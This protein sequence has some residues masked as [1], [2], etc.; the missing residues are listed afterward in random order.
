MLN[1]LF[2]IPDAFVTQAIVIIIAVA[3]YIVSALSGLYKGIQILSRFNV[4]LALALMAWILLFGPTGFIINAYLQGV[5]KFNDNFIPL[6]TF[7][8]SEGWLGWWTVFFWG[9]FL[10][11]GPAMAIFIARI[12][13]G[14]RIRELII[15]LSVIAPLVTMFWFTIVGGTGLENEIA[16][17]GTVSE[18][19]KGFNLPGALLSITSTLPASGLISMLFL[20]LT[21]IFI[22]TTGDSIT[23]T[24]SAVVTGSTEPNP[25]VRLILGILLGVTAIILISLGSG[26]ISAL[27]SFIV[28]TAV[29]VSVILLPSLW[30]APK[31]AR[32][33]AKQQKLL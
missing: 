9:W 29:P 17:P 20:I 3:I 5:G 26:G 33:M 1:S 15:A 19:F 8:A 23:Y 18:A 22:V 28:I 27:Q 32:D 2:S 21:T 7:R 11:Y 31:I 14:R 16:N 12:S 24:M 4:I 13:R 30:N 6:A 10:G 25:V